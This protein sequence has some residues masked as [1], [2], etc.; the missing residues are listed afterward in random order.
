MKLVSIE[1]INTFFQKLGQY[2]WKDDHFLKIVDTGKDGMKIHI[3]QTA[4]DRQ[5]VFFGT[6]QTELEFLMLLKMLKLYTP[7]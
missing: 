3:W 5:A 1:H 7:K 2:Y 4:E 6:V